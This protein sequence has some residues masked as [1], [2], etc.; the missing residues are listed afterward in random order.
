VDHGPSGQAVSQFTER[1]AAVLI[2][3][4]IP[5]MPARVFAALFAA[6]SGR[7]TAAD[8]AGQLQASPAAVSG[9]VRYLIQLGMARREGEPGSRRHYYRVPDDVW[10]EVIGS[11]DRV[12]ARWT[13]VLREGTSLFGAG[14]RAGARMAESARYFEFLIA[15]MPQVMARWQ[16]HKAAGQGHRG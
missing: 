11:R 15:E 7:L 14:S 16:D 12:L 8:L 3:S 4:G 10:D 13:A 6:D 5:R 9:G 2:E 1:F